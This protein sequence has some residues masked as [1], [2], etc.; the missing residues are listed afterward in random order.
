M[1]GHIEEQMDSVR[2]ALHRLRRHRV[3]ILRVVLDP[4]KTMPVIETG[5]G[6]LSWVC[7]GR[8]HDD[9]GPYLDLSTQF[10]GVELRQ[11]ARD[12]R[13]DHGR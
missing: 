12:R 5:P 2:R 4:R 6:P 3:Q 8:G 1:S 13:G 11:R 10:N 7:V 9:A